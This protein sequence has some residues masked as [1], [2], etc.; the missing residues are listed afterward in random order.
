MAEKNYVPNPEKWVDYFKKVANG[1]INPTIPGKNGI[2]SIDDDTHKVARPAL[3]KTI[4]VSPTEQTLER[5]KKTTF[6]RR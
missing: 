6:T 3:L 2:I 4:A 5:V 1:H